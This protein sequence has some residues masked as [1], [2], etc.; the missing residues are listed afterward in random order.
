MLDGGVVARGG[1]LAGAPT[2][3]GSRSPRCSCA[4]CGPCALPQWSRRSPSLPSWQSTRAASECGLSARAADACVGQLVRING[5]AAARLGGGAAEIGAARGGVCA[6]QA[7]AL[8]ALW[9][10]RHARCAARARV[11]ASEGAMVCSAAEPG[12]RA[13]AG[14]SVSLQWRAPEDD[15]SPRCGLG[16]GMGTLEFAYGPQP[17]CHAR[18]AACVLWWG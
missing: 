2:L 7:A 4:Q 14:A 8:A 11:R 12:R 10:V 13:C 18:A 17:I 16:Q 6:G 15:G 3:R 9:R 5:R 1:G